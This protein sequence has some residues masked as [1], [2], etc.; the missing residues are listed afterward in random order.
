[1]FMIGNWQKFD[2]TMTFFQEQGWF[3]PSMH[4]FNVSKSE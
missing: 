2:L 4:S 1:M 3:L